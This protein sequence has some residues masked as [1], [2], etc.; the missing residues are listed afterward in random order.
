MEERK[1]IQIVWAGDMPDGS[2]TLVA[3]CNDGT[4]WSKTGGHDWEEIEPV[5]QPKRGEAA[6]D[7]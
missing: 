2:S 6:G 4:L 3:L 7:R 1:I 5:P